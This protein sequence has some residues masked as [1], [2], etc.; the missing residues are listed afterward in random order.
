MSLIERAKAIC[1]SPASEWTTIEGERAE[2]PAL[3]IGYVLPLAGVAAVAQ[4]IGLSVV[5][6]SFGLLGT[7]RMPFTTGLELA[8]ASLLFAV[9]G[10]VVLSF[11]I[12]ALAPT[13]GAEKSRERAIKV[14]VY[15]A[16]PVWVAGVL[17]IVPA[18]GVVVLL[19]SLY[20]LYLLYLG[21][22]RLMKC[23]AE[24]SAGYLGSVIASAIVIGLVGTL[25]I[26]RLGRVEATTMAPVFDPSVY[27]ER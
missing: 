26:G 9:V 2:A 22:P 12:D 23:P 7:Y 21:L 18:L 17:Q 11:I 6:Q 16:T 20:A 14:A 27:S 10:V 25:V 5:G 4:L 19:G 13:F 8:I 1:L 3:I 24:K 15:S